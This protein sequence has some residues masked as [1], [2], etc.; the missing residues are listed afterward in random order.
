MAFIDHLIPLLPFMVCL[1]WTVHAGISYK[2]LNRAQRIL[3][4]FLA[5]SMLLFLYHAIYYTDTAD[6]NYNIWTTIYSWA[7]LSVYPLYYLYIKT[8]TDN[9]KTGKA[10]MALLFIP[11]LI[12][13]IAH[14][15]V[16][17][18]GL[19][20]QVPDIFIK[21]VRPLQTILVSVISISNLTAFERSIYDSYSDVEG[22]SARPVIILAAVQLIATVCTVIL[23][24]L[25][26]RFFIDKAVLAVPSVLFSGIIYAI[27]YVGFRYRFGAHQME[28]ELREDKTPM[29]QE[30]ETSALYH[31]IMDKMEKEHMFLKPGLSVVD[32]AQSIG[33]NRSYVSNCINTCCGKSFALFI[34][35]YRVEY[36][37]TI[38]EKDSK[39]S[40]AQVSE[41]S[42]FASEESFRRN[43]RNITGKSP[44]DW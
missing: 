31:A 40:I 25:G 9:D 23:S 44:S 14:I 1:F 8:I 28:N 42:G 38:M 13:A 35:T 18:L 26:Q 41:L 15:S 17:T 21:I 30:K 29:M 43:F 20:P 33:S 34:N 6:S 12:A 11:G 7:T 3:G 39:L 32:L 22:K 10:Q 4:V 36:A 24:I 37:K 5:V 19:N 2:D 27:A 16:L